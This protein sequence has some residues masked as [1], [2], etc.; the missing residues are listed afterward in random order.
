[1]DGDLAEDFFSGIQ[2]S[3]DHNRW[4]GGTW[5]IDNDVLD[6]CISIMKPDARRLRRVSSEVPRAPMSRQELGKILQYAVVRLAYR[7]PTDA[8]IDNVQS[9]LSDSITYSH[10][11]LAT[12]AATALGVWFMHFISHLRCLG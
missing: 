3:V 12:A 11:K 5:L 1:M 6:I 4:V 9:R 10:A 7:T 2:R 8:E